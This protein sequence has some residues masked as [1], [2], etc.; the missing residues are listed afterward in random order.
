MVGF[1]DR[2][3]GAFL[4]Q[5]IQINMKL[6]TKIWI[7]I[8][9]FGMKSLLHLADGF[10]SFSAGESYGT[11]GDA[12]VTAAIM[13]YIAYAIY[14]TRN[15]WTYWLAVFF[16]GL[17]LFR[18][19]MAMVFMIMSGEI[20]SPGLMTLAILNGL[21]FGVGPIA[22]LIQSQVRGLFTDK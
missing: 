11:Y 5:H 3:S 21:I 2:F 9:L 4:V 10:G 22:I 6:D 19:G 12:F 18:F 15:K 1:G 7:L 20:L 8:I 14:S 17:V 16:S 13:G